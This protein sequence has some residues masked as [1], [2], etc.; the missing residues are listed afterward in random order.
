VRFK[1]LRKY[2]IQ[3]EEFWEEVVAVFTDIED[4]GVKNVL[5]SMKAL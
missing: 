4:S 5:K 2:K 1:Q 3:F